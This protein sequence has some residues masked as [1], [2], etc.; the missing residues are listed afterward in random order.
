MEVINLNE[1]S[2]DAPNPINNLIK[3]YKFLQKTFVH[4]KRKT[5][6]FQ[7]ERNNHAHFL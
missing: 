7:C 6:Q 4:N 5:Y 1:S 2:I 3:V